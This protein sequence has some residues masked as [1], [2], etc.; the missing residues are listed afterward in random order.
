MN[1]RLAILLALLICVSSL[2]RA[3]QAAAVGG[4]TPAGLTRSE[5]QRAVD[6]LA[7]EHIGNT[8]AGAAVI[9]IRDGEILLRISVPSPLRGN[10]G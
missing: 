2:S 1:K 8:V 4:V 9:V 5:L 10:H 6:D 7:A 3:T